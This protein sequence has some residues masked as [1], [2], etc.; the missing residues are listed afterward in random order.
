MDRVG[1]ISLYLGGAACRRACS[2]GGPH[3][4]HP[5]RTRK[6]EPKFTF[7]SLS[8]KL[9]PHLA[10]ERLPFT[11]LWENMKFVFLNYVCSEG[12]QH[13]AILKGGGLCYTGYRWIEVI[14]ND[15]GI[16]LSQRRY[17]LELLSEFGMLAC[18]P[19]KIPLYVS[20]SKNKTMK[21]IDGD[22][23]FLE[24]IIGYQNLLRY[25]IRLVAKGFSQNERINYVETFSPIVKMVTIS[26]ILLWVLV[27][28]GSC[29]PK[30]VSWRGDH[31][32]AA[33]TC[34]G[35]DVFWNMN[36]DGPRS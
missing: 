32:V 2:H 10:I 11:G 24:N 8:V 31:V 14:N 25:K 5:S 18:K 20:K 23:K 9:L 16:C 6:S 4:L 12:I 35:H 1:E 17:S 3:A 21:L 30:L 34:F 33:M 26:A 19:S 13:N 27:S 29:S 7:M 36:Y 28:L 22:E 15:Q